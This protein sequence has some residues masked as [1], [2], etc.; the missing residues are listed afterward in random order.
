MHEPRRSFREAIL[1]CLG[2]APETIE[3]GHLH[4]FSTCERRSDK[5]GWCKL[6]DD[7]RGGVFGCFRQGVSEVWVANQQGIGTGINAVWPANGSREHRLQLARQVMRATAERER[8]RRQEWAQNAKLNERLWAQCVPLTPEDPVMRYLYRRGLG[9]PPLPNVLRLHPRLPYWHD[10]AKRGTFAA[11]V[12]PIVAPDGHVVALHRTYLTGDGHKADVPS[13]KK[14]TAAAGPMSG[15]C[16]PLFVPANR[17]IGIAEGIETA[18]GAYRASGMPTVASYCA[19]NLAAWRWPTGLLRLVIFA[20]SDEAGRVAA[21][22]LQRRA[23]GAHLH[24]EVLTPNSE[25]AD[26]CDIWA[27]SLESGFEA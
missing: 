12:A 24:C 21:G 20:D 8:V 18:L 6:F 13:P 9:G 4:R 15:A 7:L 22:K 25:D 27:A 1:A 14:V 11:M 19:D 5:A 10:G 23:M 2:H 17:A 26:W 3:P 16:I